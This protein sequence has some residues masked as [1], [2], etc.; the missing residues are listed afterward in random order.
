MRMRRINGIGVLIVTQGVGVL[1][2]IDGA[3]GG[4][5]EHVPVICISG[6]IP[7]PAIQCGDLMHHTL[8]NREKGDLCRIFAEVTTVHARLTPEGLLARSIIW[9]SGSMYQQRCFR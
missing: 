6:S 3:S 7:L 8:A 4:Y 2:T 5:S 1:G 9:V